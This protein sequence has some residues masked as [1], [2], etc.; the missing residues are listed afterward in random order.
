LFRALGPDDPPREIQIEGR[1]YRR[2]RVFKHDSWAATALYECGAE[3]VVCKFNRRQP[4]AGLPMGWLGCW[5]AR[6][7]AHLYRLLAGD[8][9]VPALCGDVCVEGRPAPH[10]VA[11]A[12]VAG[13]PLTL[14]DAPSDE[15][16]AELAG[17]LE[18]LHAVGIAYVDLHKRENV[19]LGA[20]G[21]P[22]LIDFQ[23]SVC[24]PRRRP[25]TWLLRLLQRSDRYHLAKHVRRLRP[26]LS[27]RYSGEL[28]DRPPWWIRA[29]RRVAVPFR[30]LRRRLL[31]VCRVRTGRG[32]A[33]TE[34]MPEYGQMASAVRVC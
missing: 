27:A 24:L 33:H 23:I 34:F 22:Y 19:L 12:F 16:F 29:H 28:G 15:F 3:R 1:A 10:A 8:P 31:V 11:H 25:A 4:I 32:K 6:R 9:H 14:D 7:E 20:D 5:L 30:R 26:D 13:R 21:R 18:N 17:V 2:S